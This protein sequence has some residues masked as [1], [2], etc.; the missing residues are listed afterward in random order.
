MEA[1]RRFAGAQPEKA[2]VEPEARA[3][4]TDFDDSVTHFEVVHAPAENLSRRG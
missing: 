1:V 3:V 4:L 2:V